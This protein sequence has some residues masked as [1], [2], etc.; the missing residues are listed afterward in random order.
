[1]ELTATGNVAINATTGETPA[2]I[3]A[4]L[5]KAT[6]NF[7]YD[8][9]NGKDLRANWNQIQ[10]MI[11]NEHLLTKAEAS[12][13][14]GVS[15]GDFTVSGPLYT[16]VGLIVNDNNTVKSAAP[17]FSINNDGRSAN[18][19]ANKISGG[20]FYLHGNMQGQYADSD[21]VNQNLRNYLSNDSQ[22]FN[23]RFT[24]ADANTVSLSSHV[25]L[26]SNN[27]NLTANS[28]KD[29]QIA[30]SK[31]NVEAHNYPEILTQNQTNSNFGAVVNLPPQIVSGLK[32]Y[33]SKSSKTAKDKL[34]CFYNTL[35]D[36]LMTKH[37]HVGSIEYFKYSDR[38]EALIG[39][40]GDAGVK[41]RK[42]ISIQSHT[43]DSGNKKFEEALANKLANTPNPS[44]L[45][46]YFHWYYAWNT[47]GGIADVNTTEYWGFW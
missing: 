17:T 20:T 47:G 18:E 12:V 37:D 39:S 34:Q 14:T 3:A 15:Y 46:V 24:Q 42:T 31:I 29:G 2:Q 35:D 25:K 21:A 26:Q 27:S 40:Y 33:F 43:E 22:L 32:Q 45:T 9:W 41:V 4:K 13:V 23:P 30:T 8:W 16:R 1:M 19:I 6:L 36:D 44:W 7:N 38:L 11:V 10:Q 28:M 5:S